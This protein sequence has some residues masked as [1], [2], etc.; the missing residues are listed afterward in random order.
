[1]GNFYLRK[2]LDFNKCTISNIFLISLIHKIAALF[3]GGS[4]IFY[5]HI[6]E[7][8][9]AYFAHKFFY[10]FHLIFNLRNLIRKVRVRF[11]KVTHF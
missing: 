11:K 9:L 6:S 5:P 1:M 4:S 8:L 7:I 3:R 2:N 10:L